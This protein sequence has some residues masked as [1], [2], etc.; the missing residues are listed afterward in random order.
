[1]CLVCT[2]AHACKTYKPSGG[3]LS[4]VLRDE[5]LLLCT[6]S[7]WTSCIHS[8]N[9]RL[10]LSVSWAECRAHVEHAWH[11]LNDREFYEI[12]TGRQNIVSLSW[13]PEAYSLRRAGSYIS[14]PLRYLQAIAV[15]GRPFAS[16]TFDY[17]GSVYRSFSWQLSDL[18]LMGHLHCTS[19]VTL[20]SRGTKP[21]CMLVE[22]Y[23]CEVHIKIEVE[24]MSICCARHTPIWIV[25][26][27]AY[28]WSSGS[29][30]YWQ[31]NSVSTS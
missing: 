13:L 16:F 19:S 27:D 29:W 5:W 3:P 18:F 14:S 2:Q 28:F 24:F 20:T 22:A 4:A 12:H 7:P 11:I 15:A 30:H 31:V 10:V 6:G 8:Q 21:S 25:F 26:N 9:W 1:M 23:I 17:I